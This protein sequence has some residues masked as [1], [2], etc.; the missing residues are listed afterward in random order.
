MRLHKAQ[1]DVVVIAEERDDLLRLA[2]AQEA[3]I[4]EDAGERIADR[5]MNQHGGDG[6]VDAAGKA[7]EHASR[8]DLMAYRCNRLAAKGGHRPIGFQPRDLVQEVGDELC[9]VRRMRDLEVELHAVIA[10]I[11]I[12]DDVVIGSGSTITKSV[13]AK[14]LAVARGKQ[15]IKE[16]YTPKAPGAE[17]PQPNKEQEQG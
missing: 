10:P 6:A 7:A 11:E 9:A 16:N 14:A 3:V 15:I 5:L 1:R 8:A 17:A 4:D 13:P 2:L 12:G